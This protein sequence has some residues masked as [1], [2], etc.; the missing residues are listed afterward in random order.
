MP[1][2]VESSARNEE[3]LPPEKIPRSS[4]WILLAWIVGVL[5]LIVLLLVGAD[6]LFLRGEVV[7]SYKGLEFEPRGDQL[8]QQ[9]N[10]REIEIQ[11]EAAEEPHTLVIRTYPQELMLHWNM[12]SPEGWEVLRERDYMRHN[13]HRVYDFEPPTSGTYLLTIERRA[14]QSARA[15]AGLLRAP[16]TDRLHVSVRKNDRSIVQRMVRRQR[17]SWYLPDPEDL[18]P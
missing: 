1:S 3:R 13:R 15:N 17:T 12:V 6:H 16:S 11:I 5:A 2:P 4:P 18:S 9:A 14:G 10:T 8:H 7:A